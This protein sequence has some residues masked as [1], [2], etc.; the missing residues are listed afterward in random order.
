M[1]TRCRIGIQNEDD[2]IDSIYCHH[3]GYPSH[4]YP[5]LKGHVTTEQAIRDLLSEGDLDI[6]DGYDGDNQI[7]FERFSEI[8]DVFELGHVNSL[9]E[10]VVQSRKNLVHYVYIFYPKENKW[11]CYESITGKIITEY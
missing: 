2:S 6:L 9:L 4:M 5:V 10:L 3:D 11:Q 8:K 1:S 7:Y